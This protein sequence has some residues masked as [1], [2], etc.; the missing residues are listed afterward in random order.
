MYVPQRRLCEKQNAR[1]VDEWAKKS[2][3]QGLQKPFKIDIWN[4][5]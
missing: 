4:R 1:K 3:A 5:S 2:G